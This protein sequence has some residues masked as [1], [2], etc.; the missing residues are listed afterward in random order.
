MRLGARR[1]RTQVL[2]AQRVQP[3]PALPLLRQ[4]L[5]WPA[6]SRDKAQ[7]EEDFVTSEAHPIDEWWRP[8]R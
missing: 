3:A 2:L 7:E 4:E 1:Q 6:A 5:P 8:C